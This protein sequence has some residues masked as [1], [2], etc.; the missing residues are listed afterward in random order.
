MFRPITQ[1]PLSFPLAAAEMHQSIDTLTSL[2]P[3]AR[4]LLKHLGTALLAERETSRIAITGANANAFLSKGAVPDAS[5]LDLSLFIG[6]ERSIC[7]AVSDLAI[8]WD[9]TDD[10]ERGGAFYWSAPSERTNV[11]DFDVAQDMFLPDHNGGGWLWEIW[12][13]RAGGTI[14]Y[15]IDGHLAEYIEQFLTVYD[16]AGDEQRVPARSATAGNPRRRRP[17]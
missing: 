16:S 4:A 17:A 14:P 2:R 10:G 8:G 11:A 1:V 3:T 12:Y 15:S 5:H 7:W 9:H 6:V 13:P